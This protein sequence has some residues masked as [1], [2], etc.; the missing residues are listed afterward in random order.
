MLSTCA[1]PARRVGRVTTDVYASRAGRVTFGVILIVGA[2]G[3]VALAL[4]T[5]GRATL[6]LEPEGPATPRGLHAWHVIVAS[7]LLAFIAARV[8][9]A[10]ET[11]SPDAHEPDALRDAALWVPSV[12][13]ALL[14]PLT[15]HMLVFAAS[16][17]VHAF[18]QWTR[19][20]IMFV[21][22]THIVFAGLVY[23]RARALMR[24]DK[25]ISVT[26]LYIVTCV[27]AAVPFGVPVPYV[28]VTGIPIVPLLIWMKRAARIERERCCGM[29][30]AIARVA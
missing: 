29:P 30:I 16:H 1:V 12:G 23:L 25:P 8:A 14:L 3:L 26:W 28:A 4:G 27:F 5:D 11:R 13:I 9:A 20:G 6:A 18:D 22:H 7:W 19:F 21:G 24:G 15:L 10:I 2:F 17:R